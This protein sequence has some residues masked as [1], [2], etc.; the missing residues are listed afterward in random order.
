MG[1]LD[2]NLHLPYEHNSSTSV[3]KPVRTNLQKTFLLLNGRNES[4]TGFWLYCQGTS[5]S[6]TDVSFKPPLRCQPILHNSPP[7]LIK[8]QERQSG[9][10]G[11][12]AGAEWLT[13]W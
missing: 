2:S 13:V 9:E 3:A 10:Y 8:V 1:Q 7:I 5:Y 11:K 6:E 4:Y 12:T